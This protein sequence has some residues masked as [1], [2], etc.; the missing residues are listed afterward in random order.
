MTKV[1]GRIIFTLDRTKMRTG[2]SATRIAGGADIVQIV[3]NTDTS[4]LSAFKS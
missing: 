3:Y 4:R 2:R 1:P